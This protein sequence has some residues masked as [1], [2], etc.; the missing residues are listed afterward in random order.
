MNENQK[1]RHARLRRAQLEA[2]ELIPNLPMRSRRIAGVRLYE[3]VELR[4]LWSK[5][6]DPEEMEDGAHDEMLDEASANL[7]SWRRDYVLQ[8]VSE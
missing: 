7:A 3:G 6:Y 8:G 4:L 1:R 5:A 2:R